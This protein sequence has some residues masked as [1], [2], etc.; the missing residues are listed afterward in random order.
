MSSGEGREIAVAAAEADMRLDRWFRRHYPGVT[1]GHIEKLLRTGQIRVGGKRVK[2]GHRLAEGDRV[3]VPPIG[4][5]PAPAVEKARPVAARDAAW[6]KAAV[7]YTDDDVIAIA[8]PA[9]LA[10]QGGSGT[11][12]HL[13]QMLDALRF[14]AAERPRLVHRLDRDTSG[15][16]LLARSAAAAA[17]LATAFKHRE[18][19]KV[20]WALVAGVPEPRSG[21]IDLALTKDGARGAATGREQVRVDP[22]DGARAITHYTTLDTAGRKVSFLALAPVTGRTHQIRV[23]CAAIGHPI[24]GDAKYGGAGAFPELG[25]PIRSLML[26]AREI[27]LPGAAGRRPLQVVAPVPA[28]MRAICAF[29]GFDP[30]DRSD[31]FPEHLFSRH[32]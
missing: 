22:E 13:D 9:G 7:L 28:A 6:L 31:P 1:Q 25:Q 24:L 30:E 10:V 32:G 3:R 8:K 14:G 16:L 23:H 29:L 19:R 2:A 17:R 15:V 26:H 4:I 18:T 11:R 5:A 20:Y 12:R 21:T 27:A